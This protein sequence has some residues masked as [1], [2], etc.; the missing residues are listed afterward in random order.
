MELI[1]I[2]N[3]LKY[4]IVTLNN[5]MALADFFHLFGENKALRLNYR[6]KKHYQETFFLQCKCSRHTEQP[7]L[8]DLNT[9]FSIPST[10]THM[11]ARPLSQTRIHTDM[12]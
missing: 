9:Q 11:P 2:G 7:E 6:H 12:K 10:N 3:R 4:G 5:L 8:G 1:F